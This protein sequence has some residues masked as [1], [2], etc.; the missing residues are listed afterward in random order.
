[1]FL[2][3]L[4]CDSFDKVEICILF[5]GLGYVCVLVFFIFMLMKNGKIIVLIVNWR[6]NYC[7]IVIKMSEVNVVINVL[8]I[9]MVIWVF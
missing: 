5:I 1:M 8:L 9:F 3:Y 2:I 4:K 6:Y 7:L